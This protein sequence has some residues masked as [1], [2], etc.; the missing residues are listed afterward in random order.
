MRHVPAAGLR[1]LLVSG[2]LA[3]C[4]ADRREDASGHIFRTSVENGLEIVYSSGTPK[5]DGEIFAY[6]RTIALKEDER[7]TSLIVR[8]DPPVMDERGNLYMPDNSPSDY[9][10][11]S[12][13]MVYDA[14]G[15]FL[16]A[17]GQ[18][19]QGPGDMI[20]PQILHVAG[21]EIATYDPHQRRFSFYDTGGNLRRIESLPSWKGVGW[22]RTCYLAGEGRFV[23]PAR[24]AT[25]SVMEQFTEGSLERSE[26]QLALTVFSAEWDTLC[27]ILGEPVPGPKVTRYEGSDGMS[28]GIGASPQFTPGPMANYSSRHGIIATTGQEPTLEVYDLQGIPRLRIRID[29]PRRA[30]TEEDRRR[31]SD[32]LTTSML[33]ARDAREKDY[34]KARLE[35]LEFPEYMGYWTSVEVDDFG[36]IWIE[37][38]GYVS[39]PEYDEDAVRYRVL[40]PE[41]EYLGITQLP[42]YRR[43][44]TRLTR[45]YLTVVEMDRETGE[46]EVVA[47]RIVSAHAGLVYPG[48]QTPPPH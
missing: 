6:E 47:Y 32:P 18:P 29:L 22:V 12:R 20:H 31:V 19:G 38:P 44:R 45:G 27:T 15:S 3:N 46:K 2:L 11:T 4:S 17:F 26:S 23:V 1:L 30:V 28:Y 42:T 21:G 13:I 36:F 24:R 16:F 25:A 10:S 40:S 35:S 5:Y 9:P 43:G 7:E 37:I 48:E 8:G 41:F 34:Y 39:A 14:E 33:E